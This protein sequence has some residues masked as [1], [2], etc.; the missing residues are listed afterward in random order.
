MESILRLGQHWM[1]SAWSLVFLE[2][3][4]GFL[5]NSRVFI[6][7]EFTI[8]GFFLEIRGFFWEIHEFFLKVR[9]VFLRVRGFSQTG[10]ILE[11]RGF[12]SWTLRYLQHAVPGFLESPRV[13]LDRTDFLQST[14]PFWEYMASFLGVRRI[15]LRD[16][17]CFLGHR[18]GILYP[19]HLGC[20]YTN[21]NPLFSDTKQRCRQDTSAKITCG[22]GVVYVIF[23]HTGCFAYQ[24]FC[25]P[26]FVILNRG[27]RATGHFQFRYNVAWA[28]PMT[29]THV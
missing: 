24:G 6:H 9:G 29:L 5:G 3:S 16:P 17:R 8:H 2:S 7:P 21:R 19:C 27:S 28:Q 14:A 22:Q 11:I 15:P 12:I 23:C 10:F 26:L 13:L 1:M 20:V 18:G 4:R 25:T